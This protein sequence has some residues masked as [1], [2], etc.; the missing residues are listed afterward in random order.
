M[1]QK[2]ILFYHPIFLDGGVEKTNLLISEN[3]SKK[4]KILFA[5]NYFSSKFQSDIKRFGIKKIKLK[6]ERTILSFFEL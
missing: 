3:L 4:Y 1:S 6:A 2:K 5:S